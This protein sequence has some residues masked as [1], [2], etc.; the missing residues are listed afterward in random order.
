[1]KYDI[2]IIIPVFN[3]AKTI[4]HLL[5]YLLKNISS[6]NTLEVIVVDGGSSDT[7]QNIVSQ[8]IHSNTTVFCNHSIKLI[9]S[10]KGRAKQMN[11]GAKHANSSIFYFL[12]AD[13]YPPIHFDQLITNEINKDHQAGCFIMKFNSSHLWLKLAGWLTQLPWRSCRGGDQ[14]Q[15]ITKSL[16]KTIGGYNENYT[17]YEDNDLIAKLYAR[18]Q[19][20]VIKKWL[21]TSARCYRN[22]GV[23]RLQ[24][25]FWIIHLKNRFGADA[26]T[27]NSYYLKHI[28]VKKY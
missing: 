7:S 11:L 16:F 15:F 25:H 20:V 12:H 26:K 21:T 14:S 1:M 17:I 28:C 9:T 8:F 6:D 22:N 4:E 2:S 13:S 24:Y 27:L 5:N 3:E 23:W 19:F 10:E 18:K